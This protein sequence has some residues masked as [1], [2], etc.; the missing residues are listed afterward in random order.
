M[1]SF[2]SEDLPNRITLTVGQKIKQAREELGLNQKSLAEDAYI[3]VS[4]LSKYEQGTK[5][6]TIT[7]LIYLAGA[8]R[9]P[10]TFFFPEEIVQRLDAPYLTT[11]EVE[12]LRLFRELSAGEQTRIFA[13]IRSWLQIYDQGIE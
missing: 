3:N 10:L 4:T 11:A 2:Q 6:L 7:E 9:K 12:L 8:L 5:T 13:T 1:F